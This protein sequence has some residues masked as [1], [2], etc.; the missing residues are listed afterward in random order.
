MT[1]PT[2][3]TRIPKLPIFQNRNEKTRC[4]FSEF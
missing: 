1:S 4:I 3:K 2:K